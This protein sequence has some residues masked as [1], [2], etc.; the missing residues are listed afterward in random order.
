MYSFVKD[1]KT[2]YQINQEHS[3][4]EDSDEQTEN[5]DN[6]TDSNASVDISEED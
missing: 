5:D 2:H 6:T 3:H 1:Y 4:Y